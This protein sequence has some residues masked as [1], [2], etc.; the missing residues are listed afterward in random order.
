MKTKMCAFFGLAILFFSACGNDHV[1]ELKQAQRERDSVIVQSRSYDSSVTT[2]LNYFADIQNAL[3]NI[4]QK[5]N[6]ISAKQKNS[7]L[8]GNVKEEINNDIQAINDLLE[9]NR[10]SISDLNS[11]LAKSQN[12]NVKLNKMIASLNAQLLDKNMELAMLNEDLVAKDNTIKN[13][14][15]S[16][17]TIT[18]DGMKKDDT[19]N[20][21]RSKLNEAYYVIGNFKELQEKKVVNKEGGFLGLGKEKVLSENFNRDAFKT[22]DITKTTSL[23]VS[24]KNVKIITNH[25]SDSYKL[26]RDDKKMVTGIVI[27]NPDDFWKAS[28]YLVILVN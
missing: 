17:M 20:S 9:E 16:M 18:M 23:P 10:K 15:N 27:T 7:E 28:K 5:E 2:Y 26:E 4:K 21:Q 25:P 11:K 22:I 24:G 1:T 14:N 19:I 12:K 13:L 3:N 8:K 6:I